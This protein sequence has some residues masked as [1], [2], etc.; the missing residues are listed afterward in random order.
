MPSLLC[1]FSKKSRP[2]LYWTVDYSHQGMGLLSFSRKYIKAGTEFVCR[3][4]HK[5]QVKWTKSHFAFL[6]SFGLE[7]V[8]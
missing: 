3:K 8:A 1:P 7:L 4:N 2:C 5:Y 6:H